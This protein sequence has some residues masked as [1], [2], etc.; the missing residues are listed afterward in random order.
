LHAVGFRFGPEKFTRITRIREFA[1]RIAA[2]GGRSTNLELVTRA[3]RLGGNG[4]LLANGLARLGVPVDYVGCVGLPEPHPAFKDFASHARVHS[5]GEP[6][7]T[8]AVE[9]DDGK[10]MLGKHE[11]LRGIGWRSVLERIPLPDFRRLSAAARLVAWLNWTCID[12]MGEI[13]ERFLAEVASG[14]EGRRRIAFFDLSDPAKRSEAALRAVLELIS[15]YQARF[16]VV[17]GMNFAESVKIAHS[18]GLPA[19]CDDAQSALQCASRLR[20]SLGITAVTVHQPR[21]AVAVSAQE[22]VSK[23]AWFVPQPTTSTGAGD[24]YN[25]GF[26]LGLLGEADLGVCVGSGIAVA[27]RYVRTGSSPT[28]TE[29]RAFL[30]ELSMTP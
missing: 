19:P 30:N 26:C 2:A 22:E 18:R 25:A 14:L 11:S 9:F 3:V 23:P 21:W 10:I 16:D 12:G 15:A 17:L 6:A 20:A 13:L 5:I 8:D 24:H 27:G 7:F 4:P 29:L 28:L 1:D